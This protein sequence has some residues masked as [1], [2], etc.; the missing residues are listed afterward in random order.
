MLCTRYLPPP[1]PSYPALCRQDTTCAWSTDYGGNR[2]WN[3]R[4]VTGDSNSNSSS[5]SGI[6]MLMV[7]VVVVV[8]VLVVVAVMVVMVMLVVVCPPC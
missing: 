5:N 8:V 3:I 2:L 7:M 1:Y 4:R 6:L